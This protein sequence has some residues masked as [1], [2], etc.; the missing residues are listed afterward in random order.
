MRA[1]RGFTLLELL[2]AI[3]IFGLVAAM[4]YGGLNTV[5]SARERIAAE[6]ERLAE[7]E[8]ALLMLGRDVSQAVNRPV[9]DSL[10]DT[11]PSLQGGEALPL[12]LTRAGWANPTGRARS[13]LQRIT[14]GVEEEHLVRAG[15]PVLD[16][17]HDT[18][19][20]K[21]PLLDGV[22]GFTLEFLAA[23]REWHERWPP[24]DGAGDEMPIALRIGLDLEA[25]G[26]IT[27]LFR[28]PGGGT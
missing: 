25:W 23:D 13:T 3:A 5:L 18:E 2:M 4:A 28:L 20:F 1:Q 22:R 12:E 9:R 16:R 15:W 24:P 17:A 14:W 21:T 19:P 7:L 11:L 10:G 26:T 8:T 27:R 6:S